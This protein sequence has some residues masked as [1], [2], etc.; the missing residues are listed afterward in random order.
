M[1][2]TDEEIF[3]AETYIGKGTHAQWGNLNGKVYRNTPRTAEALQN[4]IRD[5]VASISADDLQP[6]FAGIP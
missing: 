5:V 3:I 1:Y 4:E 6:F 2:T